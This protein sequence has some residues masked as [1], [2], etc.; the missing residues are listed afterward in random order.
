M[1]LLQNI[2]RF[3]RTNQ[4]VE[5]H[6]VEKGTRQGTQVQQMPYNSGLSPSSRLTLNTPL[7]KDR[8][9]VIRQPIVFFQLS[10]ES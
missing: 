4:V 6:D 9:P 7:S 5:P 10:L 8:L 2:S 3:L 1:G